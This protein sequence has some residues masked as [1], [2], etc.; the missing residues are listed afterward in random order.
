[1]KTDAKI[2]FGDFQTPAALAGEV[3]ALLIRK[4][5]NADL[6]VE[7]TCG[8]GTFL[9]AA[10]TAFP[11]ASLLGWD[12]NGAYVEEARAALKRTGVG[13]RAKVQAQDFFAQYWDVSVAF[14]GEARLRFGDGA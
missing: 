4:G 2:E 5:I 7:P 13:G 14:R 1:M 3:C 9:L 12:V 10:A 11:K 6:V 8:V